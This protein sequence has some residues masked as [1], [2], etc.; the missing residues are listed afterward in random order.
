MFEVYVKNMM[1]EAEKGTS[2]GFVLDTVLNCTI[3]A[4]G[5]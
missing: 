3:F 2:S 5:Y 1:E 4:S